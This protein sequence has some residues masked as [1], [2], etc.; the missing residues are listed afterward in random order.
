MPQ[1][2]DANESARK[3]R[4][5]DDQDSVANRL[6]AIPGGQQLLQCLLA[7]MFASSGQAASQLQSS[8]SCRAFLK[9]IDV[10]CEGEQDVIKEAITALSGGGLGE[11]EGDAVEICVKWLPEYGSSVLSVSRATDVPVSVKKL[12]VLG[13]DNWEFGLHSGSNGYEHTSSSNGYVILEAGRLPSDYSFDDFLTKFDKSLTKIQSSRTG[14]LRTAAGG[15]QGHQ[16]TPAFVYAIVSDVI[17]NIS[18]GEDEVEVQ[19]SPRGGFTDVGLHTGG[20]PRDTSLSLVLA[21]VEFVVLSLLR[22]ESPVGELAVLTKLVNLRLSILEV[23][24]SSA[25]T[26]LLSQQFLN[27]AVQMMHVV[28]EKCGVAGDLGHDF[29]SELQRLLIARKQLD[30]LLAERSADDAK[31][32]TLEQ[33]PP[34]FV[35]VSRCVPPVISL[36]PATGHVLELGLDWASLKARAKNNLGWLPLLRPGDD[37]QT[38]YD[39]LMAPQHDK[40]TPSALLRLQTVEAVMFTLASGGFEVSSKVL[41]QLLQVVDEYRTILDVFIKS[42]EAAVLMQTEL[43]SR[44]FVVTWIAYCCAFN[45]AKRKYSAVMGGFGVSLKATDLRHLVLSSRKAVDAAL[46]VGEFLTVHYT[47]KPIFQLSNEAPTQELALKFSEQSEPILA[48]WSKEQKN[49]ETRKQLHW[50]EVQRKQQE[51]RELRVKISQTSTELEQK[52]K[53]LSRINSIH[54]HNSYQ[55][56]IA[57]R[58]INVLTADLDTLKSN[59]TEAERAPDPVIQPLPSDKSLALKVLFTLH[60]PKTFRMLSRLSFTAQQLLLPRPW[61][62]SVSGGGLTPGAEEDSSVE[63]NVKSKVAVA[64]HKTIWAGHYN[65]YKKGKYHDSSIIGDSVSTGEVGFGC[66]H[67]SV[68]AMKDIGP[69]QVDSCRS[70]NDGVWHPNSVSLSMSWSG[71]PLPFDKMGSTFN[72]WAGLNPVWTAISFTELLP[73]KSRSLQ[74]SLYQPSG[75]EAVNPCR[76]NLAISFQD[77]KPSWLNKPAWLS[78]CSLRAYPHTQL[79]DLCNALRA[80]SLPLT[81]PE[82][83]TLIKLLLFHLGEVA[84][85]TLG[86]GEAQCSLK[87]KA[88]LHERKSDIGES[89]CSVLESLCEDI[90]SAPKSGSAVRILGETA[91]FLS[92]W[93]APCRDVARKFAEAAKTWAVALDGDIENAAPENKAGLR[94][95]QV[96]F[97][98][99]ATLIL[100]RGE[101][102]AADA[103]KVVAFTVL[104]ENRCSDFEPDVAADVARLKV[105]CLA[106]LTERASEYVEHLSLSH[107]HLTSAVKGVFEA[108]PPGLEWKRCLFDGNSTACFESENSGD[109]FSINVLNGVILFNGKPPSQLPLEVLSHPLYQRCFGDTRFEVVAKCTSEMQTITPTDGRFYRFSIFPDGKLEIKELSSL[110]A[111]EETE[112]ELLDGIDTGWASEL[113]VRLRQLHSHWV[114]RARQ[115]VLLRGISFRDRGID[116]IV[117]CA[118]PDVLCVPSHMRDKP[119]LEILQEHAREPFDRLVLHESVVTELLVRFE[120]RKYIHTLLTGDQSH[121]TLL[122]DLPRFQ[123]SLILQGGLLLSREKADYV[124]AKEQHLTSTLSGLRPTLSGLRPYLLLSRS[125]ENVALA[126]TCV[127]VPDGTVSRSEGCVIITSV[128][129]DA[130]GTKRKYFS[131]D[132]H[133]RMGHLI[134]RSI[135]SRLHLAALYAATATLVPELTLRMTGIEQAMCLVRQCGV[136]RPLSVLESDKLYNVHCLSKPAT[137]CPPHSAPLALLVNLLWTS[138]SQLRLLHA[139]E[140]SQVGGPAYTDAAFDCSDAMI[141]YW[142]MHSRQ[143]SYSHRLMLTEDEERQALCGHP[144]RRVA[145]LSRA[146]EASEEVKSCVCTLEDAEDLQGRLALLVRMSEPPPPR[147][148]PLINIS[149]SK[150]EVERVM[151]RD[152]E[153]SWVTNSSLPVA[154][155]R[156]DTPDQTLRALQ[157]DVD[158]RVREVEAFLYL[159]MTAQSSPSWQS[160]SYRFQVAAYILPTASTTDYIRMALDAS[161][162]GRFNPLLTDASR[163]NVWEALI[164]LL[165]LY[166]L[167][168]KMARCVYYCAN[169]SA[170]LLKELR[171]VR[172]WSPRDHPNWLAFEVEG[173]LQ[174]RPVQY[175]IAN[176]LL[177]EF[178]EVMQLNMGEGKT[179]VILPMLILYWAKSRENIIRLTVPSALYHETCSFMQG[180]LGASAVFQLKLFFLP[181]SRDVDLIGAKS[182]LL[183]SMLHS[184]QC[185]KRSGGLLLCAPEHTLSLELKRHELR[186]EHDAVSRLLGKIVDREAPYSFIDIVD[187]VDDVLHVRYQLVYAVGA[188]MPLS[189]GSN[190]WLGVQA[191]LRAIQD[192]DVS[193]WLFAQS[194]VAENKNPA[195][196]AFHILRELQFSY[197]ESTRAAWPA[198]C[199]K[200]MAK[201]LSDPPHHLKWLEGSPLAEQIIAAT[202]DSAVSIDPLEARLGKMQ[203]NDVLIL[204]G[205]L[206]HG[207]ALHCLQMRHRVDFG[208]ARPG[209]KRM[210][211]PFRSSDQPAER[212]EFGHPDVGIMLSVLSYTY[213]GLSKK[214]LRD[215]FSALMQL[216]PSARVKIYDCWFSLSAPAM[217]LTER[218]LVDKESK[219]DISNAQQ[220]DLLHRYY[221]RNFETVFFWINACVFGS[222]TTQFPQRLVA[223]AWNLAANPRTV[224]FSG[225]N[226]THLLLP[227]G[228]T[229]HQPESNE[230]GDEASIM[231]ATNGLMLDVILRNPEVIVVSKGG[232]KAILKKALQLECT[233]IIDSGALLAGVKLAVA[234]KWL[235]SS[236][237]MPPATKGISFFDATQW[238]VL[239]RSGRMLPLG[240]SPVRESETFA[241]FDEARCRGADLKLA[242]TAQALLTLGPRMG[243]DKLMQAAGR[244]RQITD[245]QSL[246]MV[247]LDALAV[248]I[249]E[250]TCLAANADLTSATVL[251]WVLLNTAAAI[252]S[253]LAEWARQ[254]SHF[255]VTQELP[256]R[257]F[258]DEVFCLRDMYAPPPAMHRGSGLGGRRG[259][260]QEQDS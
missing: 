132:I 164:V 44:E 52:K 254:G 3:R 46:C 50:A 17:V 61:E 4:K 256:E 258:L 105:C 93:V 214:E 218:C 242:P 131:Y 234:A 42:S 39:W 259:V 250:D 19:H 148:N 57:Q 14:K 237:D 173:R 251:L 123:F 33:L 184:L 166:V 230:N 241:I 255:T 114:I 165:T 43:R 222:E 239:E 119:L 235:L 104:A 186:E 58:E 153:M 154:L 192:K 80:R 156:H 25:T 149:G 151:D 201:L 231:R 150:L 206:A 91:A 167:Q 129:N 191:V 179:R 102:T 207:I 140:G 127:V 60:M 78:F 83:Q 70:P 253:W 225:T 103:G 159:A 249:R 172:S 223:T 181:F 229:Q 170:M 182:P 95:Q 133:Q 125:N 11:P 189:A 106:A 96:Q 205:L 139:P 160:Q 174:I 100:C 194:N 63:W 142:Q 217:L 200:V 107:D 220:F 168:D 32:L 110:V 247:A 13:L 59:L 97:Y 49:A 212:A 219:I 92:Q 169:S 260:C 12:C 190:R 26:D 40:K 66:Q 213:D 56:Q 8:T 208:V 73:E 84:C 244:M 177:T 108:C 198:I 157:Y 187:E 188:K 203:M 74:W 71:G 86:G 146:R 69:S 126:K 246:V 152:L 111:N 101:L 137:E 5:A 221:G 161:Y 30:T 236:P 245:K 67:S 10:L 178:G 243:K 228:M 130:C 62:N 209:K 113:P 163:Q 85:N 226:D 196:E 6:N 99:Y 158:K 141:E 90:W 82:T 183:R 65:S 41:S 138:S 134:A 51:A 55:A 18:T 197:C 2:V 22:R 121:E 211:I 185:C 54:V 128:D 89:L 175:A 204:R 240:Q 227:A 38:M 195:E 224:A 176:R 171:V 118:E 120:D 124:L 36:P 144:I 94:A 76:G 88:E 210:A 31:S 34:S 1:E 143:S 28:S 122:F 112:L 147:P 24:L 202:C 35:R 199:K 155:L 215:A 27:N 15:E 48:K 252:K 23:V 72:P 238:V 7:S 9:L 81:R 16:R 135:E 216:G 109:L 20:I 77:L 232:W 37:M 45:C 180:C 75:S 136:N 53:E 87:W 79:R 115:L 257:A 29:S 68:P 64:E 98:R 162:I 248:Q 145:R 233:V 47:E 193:E 117:R 116:F 21:A